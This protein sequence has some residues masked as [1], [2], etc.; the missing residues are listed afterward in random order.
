M[1]AGMLGLVLVIGG[2][3]LVCD[4]TGAAAWLVAAT[5]IGITLVGPMVQHNRRLPDRRLR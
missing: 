1:P 4:S 2:A 3:M 5:T